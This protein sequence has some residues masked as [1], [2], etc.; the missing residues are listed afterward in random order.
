MVFPN[1]SN[2]MYVAHLRYIQSIHEA[3]A[4]R[5][6]D[7]L[8]RRFIPIVQRLRVAWLRPAELSTLRSDP[9]YYYLIARTRYYDQVFQDA[10]AAGAR[11]IVSVGCGSDTRAYRF[12]DLLRAKGVSVLECDQAESIAVKKRLVRRW[13]HS[14]HVN[15]LPIDLNAGRW[16]ALECRLGDRRSPPT[17]VLMEG[18][19]PYIDS[20]AFTEFLRLLG[21]R[22]TPGSRVAY[23]FK[24]AG[25]R[26]D[27]GLEGR[28]EK[29][30]RLP[31]SS[32]IVASFHRPLGFELESMDLSDSLTARLFESGQA[33]AP[34]FAEDGLA[35]FRVT[36]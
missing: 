21:S 18:V 30:F 33:P 24:L 16:P 6:P 7:T 4:R 9:F 32:E 36:A 19:S 25:C 28:A 22:L 3:P 10:V 12:K 27:F 34:V 13:R 14:G 5:N 15:Y 31:A 35:L 20:P 17:F 29:L 23:D 11:H 2:S 26:D 8:V 1:L